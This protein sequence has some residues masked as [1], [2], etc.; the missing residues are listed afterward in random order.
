MPIDLESAC[1]LAQDITNVPVT[2]L[3]SAVR[4]AA[5][6]AKN[7]FHPIQRYLLPQQLKQ[8]LDGLAA[9]EIL[10]LTDPFRVRYLFFR[11]GSAPVGIGP[12]CT[13]LFSHQD[14]ETAL[15]RA[16]IRDITAQDL[17]V[18][19]GTFPV[20]A[21]SHML[22]MAR[23]LA[24]SL[25]L[26]GTLT[27]VRRVEQ[28]TGGPQQTPPEEMPRQLYA[29]MIR[30]RYQVEIEFMDCIRR[31]DSRAAIHAWQQLHQSVAYT[32]RLGQ[33]IETARNSAAVNRTTIRLAA[34]EAGIPALVN[35]LLS[36][37]SSAIVRNAKTIDEIDAEH[38]RIIRVY[39]Q[40]IRQRRDQHYSSLVLSAV[41]Q[42][43]RH[44]AEHI[45]V[46]ELAG[47]LEVSPD[48]LA[49][50]FRKET[51]QTPLA[52]LTA[53]RMRAAARRLAESDAP[54]SEIAA[55]VGI[56][57]ANYFIKL[58]KKAYGQTPLAWRKDH[59]L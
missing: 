46:Q 28:D 51:G 48:Y 55:G 32:K 43:E 15:Q 6:C 19:R 39:C 8:T 59:R 23:S 38:E 56:L 58:F 42:M 17:Q 37:E 11:L 1:R 18:M 35:D 29:E 21:E 50:R 40:A 12:F 41:Y 25:G 33:T 26:G 20:Y 45:T 10:S 53:V 3:G 36:G 47:E 22:H 16:G 57:D 27:S 30:K 44:Y 52:Y 24:R 9:G 13:E 14:C 2:P 54:V 31:G 7:Q 49:A 4:Q 34:A 5:F